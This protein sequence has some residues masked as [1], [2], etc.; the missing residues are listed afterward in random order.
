MKA[1]IVGC[2][3]IGTRHLNILSRIEEVSSI[4]V[5][6][7]VSD[8]LKKIDA[9]YLKKI[10]VIPDLDGSELDF[11]FAFICNE[12]NKHLGTALLLARKG[13]NLFIEKPVACNT[14][15]LS[16]LTDVVRTN[17][18]LVLV[19][20][21]LRFL[22]C[23]SYLNDL[24]LTRKLGVL[25]FAKIE[26]GQYLPTWRPQSDYRRSYSA[27]KEK[28]GGVSLDLSHEID[29]M[30]FLFGDPSDWN[31]FRSKVSDLEIDTEDMFEGIYRYS[32]GFMCNVHMDYLQNDKKR[33]FRLVGSKGEAVCDFINKKLTLNL[34]GEQLIVVDDPDLFNVVATYENEVSH[35]INCV[36]NNDRPL[37]SLSDGIKDLELLEVKHV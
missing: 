12:T 27:N 25:Y 7:K 16:S 19:G 13:I 32:S 8:C 21:N 11:D 17:N 5:C 18:L 36:N 4:T 2:G 34:F 9:A 35:F 14:S 6:T 33:I 31:V 28:G 3:S 26:V 23:M 22:G 24:I 1:L 37:V 10:N 30:R 15:G 20:Y 29:Y